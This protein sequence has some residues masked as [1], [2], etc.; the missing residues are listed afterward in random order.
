ME[1]MTFKAS[2]GRDVASPGTE[3]LEVRPRLIDP[4]YM[5]PNPMPG[6][7]IRSY[8]ERFHRMSG[9][10]SVK[11]T[12]EAMFG[13]SARLR[14][15][16]C[17]PS[18][19]AELSRRVGSA[20]LLGDTR[21][22]IEQ[23]TTL[24]YHCYFHTPHQR[25][26]AF[27][28]LL[29][30]RGPAAARA[31]LGLAKS[32][33]LLDKEWP[34]FCETCVQEDTARFGFTYWK[35]VHQLPPVAICP[36]HGCRLR[37]VQGKHT[38]WF[39]YGYLPPP[40]LSVQSIE[41]FALVA[42]GSGV[43]F[44]DLLRVAEACLYVQERPH[45]FPGDWRIAA[46]SRLTLLGYKSKGGLAHP[47]IVDLLVQQHGEPLLTW[48]GLMSAD[49]P[50]STKSLRSMLGFPRAR[51]PTILYIVLALTFAKNLADFEQ[52]RLLFP[53]LTD[54]VFRLTSMDGDAGPRPSS[55]EEK[56]LEV[57]AAMPGLSRRSVQRNQL[58]LHGRVPGRSHPLTAAEQQAVLDDARAGASSVELR[59]K[60]G[61]HLNDIL[62]LLERDPSARRRMEQVDFL[63]R[64][65][66]HRQS[67]LQ[68]LR[69]SE[70]HGIEYV[71]RTSSRRFKMLQRYDAEWYR[72]HFPAPASVDTPSVALQHIDE[73]DEKLSARVARNTRSLVD[74]EG[75]VAPTQADV[76]SRCRATA[77]FVKYQECL[78]RTVSV[79]A[80]LG[81]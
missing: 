43:A 12:L 65:D 5:L 32:P 54:E 57:H 15:G 42:T 11:E 49:R 17:L 67:A 71:R 55:S 24:P 39:G 44:A 41:S 23:H 2:G 81:K 52:N 38:N 9:G 16:H 59:A 22:A 13:P 60:F 8:W 53:T 33:L 31:T 34:A 27:T 63:S 40:D 36:W 29:G 61:L 66:D 25:E 78:P 62:L 77:L 72:H 14:S 80:M 69:D 4:G 10:K 20:H 6:E 28:C 37:E 68:F 79:L 3:I 21:Y 64:R 74:D 7:T 26:H 70:K 19:L 47:K 46:L 50:I 58:R 35:A 73:V 56:P 1:A 48:L 18:R 30:A 76:L 75:V 45:G 51:Q